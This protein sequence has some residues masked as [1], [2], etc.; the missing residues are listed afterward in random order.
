[1]S[2]LTTVAKQL[3]I[4]DDKLHCAIAARTGTK[5]WN[6]SQ[7]AEA[8][9]ISGIAQVKQNVKH[10]QAE[11]AALIA[12]AEAAV[13]RAKAQQVQMV[14]DAEAQSVAVEAHYDALCSK[15]RTCDAKGTQHVVRSQ[16]AR[17]AVQVL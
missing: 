12:E 10:A 14:A 17:E 15:V 16:K 4:L 1:M 8:V 6:L 7:K 9:Y 5:A 2:I 3:L 13:R 11:G